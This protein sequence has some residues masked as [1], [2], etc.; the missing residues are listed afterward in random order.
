[1]GNQEWALDARS[2]DG[3]DV[4]ELANEYELAGELGRGGSAVVYLARD[5]ALG[6]EVA[7]K[8]V[9]PRA[10]ADD[11]V[12]RLAR[13]ARTVAQ[14]QHP[15][16]VAVYAV[17][18][19]R[20]G[21]L[22]LV[23][24][25]VP[26][27][28][29]RALID[30]EAP[31]PPDR[32]ERVMRDVA[33]A[34]AYA[35]ARGVV[36]RDVKPENVFVHADDGRALL[37]DFGIARSGQ[38][39]GL[40]MAGTALG[41]P[42]YM[43]PE[44]VDGDA[45]DGRA[46]LYSLGV[47]TW[48]MLTGRRPWEGESLYNVIYKQKHDEL[49]PVEAL[50]PGAVPPRLQYVVERMLQKRPAARWAG[51]DGLLA[52]LR[53]AV[54][55]SDFGRWQAALKP[56][57]RRWHEQEREQ[58][59]EREQEQERA[60]ARPKPAPAGEALH[61]STVQFRRSDDG[62]ETTAVTFDARGIPTLAPVG[63]VPVGE[64]VPLD[65]P[66]GVSAPIAVGAP[67]AADPVHYD[68]AEPEW[69][70]PD[71]HAA[72][73]PSSRRRPLFVGVAAGALLLTGAGAA[74]V[75]WRGRPAP[76]AERP[77]A[78]VPKATDAGTPPTDP[79]PF[80]AGAS[81]AVLAV[82]GRHACVVVDDGGVTCW[83]ANEGGQ[84]GDGTTRRQ[85]GPD[86]VRLPAGAVQVAAGRAHSCAVATDG[87]AWC[88]G[89]NGEGQLGAATPATTRSTPVTVEGPARFATV[90]TGGAHSC[91]LTFT[92]AVWCWGSNARG[93]LGDGSDTLR[94]RTPTPVPVAD[95]ARVIELSLG[96]D[97]SCA[98]A[99]DGRV[100]CWGANGDG[101]LGDGSREDRR[102]PTPVRGGL[103]FAAL[104]A[105]GAFT[106]GTT[107][108][109]RVACWGRN[110][111]GQ[112]GAAN[113]RAGSTTPVFATLPDGALAVQVA[114]GARS[115]CAIGAG[116]EA[117]CWGRVPAGPA[118]GRRAAVRQPPRPLAWPAPIAALALGDAH[119]C[120]LSTSGAVQC[121]GAN[122]SRQLGDPA[123]DG[124]AAAAVPL[125]GDRVARPGAVPPERR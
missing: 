122:G 79:A 34:L 67:L 80:P 100:F 11:A 51:A 2:G 10:G 26:G 76:A 74:A 70:A 105:G 110:A 57:V 90:R 23:L 28:T 109:R 4:A 47:V 115:A 13:E 21:G 16:I 92:G 120:A 123:S 45:L 83:G 75:A 78:A 49:P 61:A 60:R 68:Q 116:G 27:T 82:G 41:T 7:I 99:A 72:L 96:R 15:N 9:T 18:R 104:S 71:A 19:L 38:Q 35:H 33:S 52:Q 6:R 36:H 65:V 86:S 94:T 32:A 101:Q 103:T 59:R 69:G 102:T 124:D 112:L 12:A 56:R 17:R 43:A 31:L 40:T 62:A 3:A 24:Q 48:E 118:G 88:W 121:W 91:G 125:G 64:R 63:S 106:C 85:T 117:W 20:S 50:R 97:H 55:P 77:V 39:D 30:R 95:G 42:A 89:A 44:Q 73:R 107:A 29:L 66:L 1:M 98:L 46:D 54:L 14:L 108:D 58:A 113:R 93:Q 114:A 84:L 53:H 37:A 22:A 8:V 119:G 81:G 5:R 87:Q 25:Y 111:D